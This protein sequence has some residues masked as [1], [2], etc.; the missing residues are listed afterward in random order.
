MTD[1]EAIDIAYSRF[2]RAEWGA[3][4]WGAFCRVIELAV[5][6]LALQPP[7]GS[8]EVKIAVVVG[9]SGEPCAIIGDRRAL[10]VLSQ[11]YYATHECIAAVWVPPVQPVPVVQGVA[12]AAAKAIGE[13]NAV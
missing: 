3:E 6:A 11:L 8:V 7:P 4:A 13:T 1:Q 12:Q 9:P 2:Q 5:Q 10:V